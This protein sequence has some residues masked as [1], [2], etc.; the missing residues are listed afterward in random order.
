LINALHQITDEGT[1][2]SA[3]GRML[4][5]NCPSRYFLANAE[6]MTPAMHMVYAHFGLT[7]TEM[8]MLATARPTQDLYYSCREL[9]QRLFHLKLSPFILDCLARNTEADHA[10]MDMLLAQEGREGF[11]RAWFA[12]HDYH[13]AAA[14][15]A[16]RTDATLDR[17]A[18]ADERTGRMYGLRSAHGYGDGADH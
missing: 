9:G 5:V 8:Q 16:R 7:E 1:A 11:A 14:A 6:A 13:E 10:R 2:L 18:A 3:L 4:Q 17:T 15:A 12:H